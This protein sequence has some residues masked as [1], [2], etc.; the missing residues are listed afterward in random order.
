M[1]TFR[2]TRLIRTTFLRPPFRSQPIVTLALLIAL[3]LL[4]LRILG[5]LRTLPIGLAALSAVWTSLPTHILALAAGPIL[6]VVFSI[7]LPIS[8]RSPDFEFIQLV[9]L[10][11]AAIPIRDSHQFADA[12]AGINRLWIVHADI[13]T[14]STRIIQ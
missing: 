3:I 11:I 10:F 14:H 6:P 2:R 12:A 8:R 1:L 5:I 7:R 9:P 4:T 13:M